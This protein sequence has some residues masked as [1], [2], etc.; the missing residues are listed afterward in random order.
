MSKLQP[1]VGYNFTSDAKGYSL[2]IETLG[3]KRAA[4]EVYTNAISATQPAV[5]VQPGS[6]NKVI[7]KIGGNYIDAAV[8]P[9]LAVSATG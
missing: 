2:S 1:G 5:S 4:L 8:I 7:P 6:V 3:R 9:Q